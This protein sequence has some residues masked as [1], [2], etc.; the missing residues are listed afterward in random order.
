MNIL[1]SKKK[2]QLGKAQ[3]DM[4][5]KWYMWDSDAGLNLIPSPVSPCPPFMF[6]SLW[7]KLSLSLKL[8]NELHSDLLSSGIVLCNDLYLFNNFVYQ[9]EITFV[10]EIWE[11]MT[12]VDTE[13]KELLSLVHRALYYL[14]KM[15]SA[16]IVTPHPFT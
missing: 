5:I 8:G 13:C 14:I 9:P 15:F 2:V 6:L 10:D 1:Q 7:T 3:V 16:E 4:A 12:S 11:Y